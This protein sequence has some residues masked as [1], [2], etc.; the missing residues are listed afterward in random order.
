MFK[1]VVPNGSGECQITYRIIT[2]VCVSDMSCLQT[3]LINLLLLLTVH[4]IKLNPATGLVDS[5]LLS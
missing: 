4:P 3:Q 2:H 5:S 1:V